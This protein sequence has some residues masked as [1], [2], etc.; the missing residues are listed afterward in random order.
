MAQISNATFS[1][2]GGAVSYLFAGF[3]AQTSGTMQQQ[4]YDIQA[5]GTE[6]SAESSEIT[7]Q[8]LRTKA[9]GDIAEA[10]NYQLAGNL[11]SENAAYTN[12]STRIQQSQA[13]RAETQTIGAQR[14][15]V[16]GA[17]F[18]SGGSAFYLMKDSANQ[19]VLQQGVIGMQGAINAA[20]Y[21]EQAQSFNTMA[22]VG[23]QTAASEN[24]IAG[25]TDTIA[26]QQQTIAQQQI[27]LGAEAKQAADEQANGDFI[28]SLLKGAAS[29]ASLAIGGPV[30]GAAVTMGLDGLEAIH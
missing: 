3:G 20:G 25:E 10:Q 22:Q 4:G 5:Q 11:A 12:I 18:S 6:I 30:A 16:G 24:Q 19:G 8:S 15:A 9:Q 13:A 14:A 17:G 21:T 26:G 23:Y 27:Q 28:G 29:V 2:L 7:A 1:D